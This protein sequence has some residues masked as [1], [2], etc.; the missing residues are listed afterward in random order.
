MEQL[1]LWM[2]LDVAYR[3][4]KI[5]FLVFIIKTS[6]KIFFIIKSKKYTALILFDIS[7]IV[8]KSY[9]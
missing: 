6:I 7:F 2:N 3:V 8:I 4:I 9:I 1:I 5:L